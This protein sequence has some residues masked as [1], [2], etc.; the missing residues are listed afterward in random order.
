MKR[1]MVLVMCVLLVSCGSTALPAQQEVQQ[2]VVQTQSERMFFVPRND[3]E[4]TNYNK[5]VEMADDASTILWCTFFP[6]TMGQEPFTIPIVGKLTSSGKRPFPTEKVQLYGGDFTQT[7]YPEE[8]QPDGMYGSSVEYRF[9]FAPDGTYVD[10][11]GLSSFCT[12]MPTVWQ[13]NRTTIITEQSDELT[14]LHT[15]AQQALG[16]GN[17]EEAM[18]LLEQAGNVGE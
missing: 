11:T 16:E 8:V 10:F 9:G 6:P 14:S 5:R 7:Y 12:T 3:L 2:E 17:V 18:S 1:M 13:A 15:Q 4:F